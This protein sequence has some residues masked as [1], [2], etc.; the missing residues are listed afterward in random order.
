MFIAQRLNRTASSFRSDMF[1]N[2][3]WTPRL[4]YYCA[5][6]GAT[7]YGLAGG[8]KHSSLRGCGEK[9]ILLKELVFALQ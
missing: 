7:K 2:A 4:K 3:G 9:N 8:Y 6:K 5:P 1:S